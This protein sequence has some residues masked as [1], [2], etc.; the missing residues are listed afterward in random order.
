MATA[1]EF[2]NPKY[3]M[4]DDA[5]LYG[6]ELSKRAL[7]RALCRFMDDHNIS[8]DQLAKRLS[9]P[10]GTVRA[11]RA[12][13][14]EGDFQL[15]T[16]CGALKVSQKDFLDVAEHEREAMFA[17]R[18]ALRKTL[19]ASDAVNHPA[20]YG[21]AEN[22]YEVIKVIDAWSL[23]FCEGNVVKYVSRAK[24]KG[25]ELEDL[26]KARWYLDHRIKQ[27]EAATS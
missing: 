19:G 10:I 4:Q 6:P 18:Q 14:Y 15:S 23:G 2:N 25:R 9:W 7:S 5:P 22:P 13:T 20:H 24:H 8:E 11:F 21:G 17:E 3:M 12:S 1:T 26:R 27:L 16:I